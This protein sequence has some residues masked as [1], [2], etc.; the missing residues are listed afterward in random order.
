MLKEKLAPY[1]E[2]LKTRSVTNREVA[3]ELGVNETYLSRVLGQ[4][5]LKK[6]PPQSASYRQRQHEL[7]QA[8]IEHRK[9]VAK[10]LPAKEAAK[11]ANCSVRTITRWKHR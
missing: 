11:A 1:L 3:A 4:M 8:R 5:G 9:N 2:L 10:T 6:D 7:F